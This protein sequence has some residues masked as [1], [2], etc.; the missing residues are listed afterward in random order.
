MITHHHFIHSEVSKG[1]CGGDSDGST[2]ENDGI[3]TAKILVFS[4]WDHSAPC[5]PAANRKRFDQTGKA[6]GDC[7]IH[8]IQGVIALGLRDENIFRKA[9]DCPCAFGVIFFFFLL[10]IDSF[11]QHEICNIFSYLYDTGDCFV[12]KFSAYINLV[13]GVRAMGEYRHICSTDAGIEVLH[14]NVIIAY[15]GQRQFPDLYRF[16]S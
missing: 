8:S 7:F 2:S 4:C 5:R 6:I 3:L 13:A 16:F 9:A 11:S 14:Q 1:N 10:G 15:L 12:S